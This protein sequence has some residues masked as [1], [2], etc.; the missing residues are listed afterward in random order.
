MKLAAFLIGLLITCV[1]FSQQ[2]TTRELIR[3][4]NTSDTSQTTKA[5]Y[6]YAD[7]KYHKDP[8]VFRQRLLELYNYLSRH[9]NDR[10]LIRTWIYEVLGKYELKIKFTPSDKRHLQKA[11][12]MAGLM[13]DDQLLSE[14]FSLYPRLTNGRDNSYY[15]MRAVEMQQ[16]IGIEHFPLFY[17]RLLNFS[18][19]MYEAAEYRAAIIYGKQA[20]ALMAGKTGP[21][22]VQRRVLALDYIGASYK[23]LGIIDSVGYYYKALQNNALQLSPGSQM[24]Q[25]WIGIA[26]GGLGY[27]KLMQKDYVAARPLLEDNIQSSVRFNQLQDAAISKDAIALIDFQTHN[28]GQALQNWRTAYSWYGNNNLGK[29]SVSLQ[30]SH[31]FYQLHNY[32]SAFYYYREYCDFKVKLDQQY[33]SQKA[34]ALQSR[35]EFNKMDSALQVAKKD[36]RQEKNIR[37]AILIGLALLSVIAILAYNRYRIKH[38][39][40]LEQISSKQKLAELEVQ[41]AKE[42]IKTFTERIQKS[43]VLIEHLKTLKPT[44]KENHL[45][46][47]NKL[48]AYSLIT[49]EGWDQFRIEFIQVYPHFYPALQRL[50]GSLTP[51]EERLTALIHLQLNNAQIANALGIAKESVSRSKRRLKARLRLS[52]EASLEVFLMQVNA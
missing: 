2:L 1:S 6:S 36:I 30:L 12:K 46:L 43:E 52:D 23:Q 3:L 45:Q 14:L 41:R 11:L 17:L 16:N 50:A 13:G 4:W 9:Q 22:I 10:I 15:A 27:Q 19:N 33:N 39:L 51:A 28:Y 48:L 44:E 29:M 25:I 18:M 42:Q 38:R 8:K 20:I 35:I 31:V 24:Q 40:A 5:E 26:K 7:L 49:N 34:E 47:E 37:L 32:D 21:E